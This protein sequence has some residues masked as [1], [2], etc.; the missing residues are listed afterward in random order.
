MA[1]YSTG[2]NKLTTDVCSRFYCIFMARPVENRL[3]E[4]EVKVKPA[5]TPLCNCYDRCAE[6]ILETNAR[7]G[8]ILQRTFSVDA[9]TE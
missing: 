9:R 8:K 6:R 2:F 4:S 3:R 5:C 7:I 1:I